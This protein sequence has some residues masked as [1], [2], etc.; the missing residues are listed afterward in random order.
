[1]SCTESTSISRRGMVRGGASLALWGLLPRP[2]IAAGRDPR[3]LCVILRGG[4][5][6]ISMVAP[7][8]DPDYERLRGK[9][10]IPRGGVGAGLPLDSFFV[11]NAGMPYLHSLYR[12]KQALILH[13]IQSPYRGRSHFDGQDVLESGLAGVGR[14]DD[15]WLNR[16]LASLPSVG[17][18]EPMKGLAMGAVVP[19]VIRGSAPIL[20]WIPKANSLPLRDSTIERLQDLYAETD[21]A[22]AKAFADGIEI[23]RV[24]GMGAGAVPPTAAK[25]AGTPAQPPQPRPFREFTDAAEAAAKFLAAPGGPRIGALSFSGWD[26]HSNEGVITGQLANRLAG[27]DACIK[28]FAEAMGAAWRETVVAIVTEFGRTAR[29]NGTDGTDHGTATVA[30]VVG[31]AVAGGR[32]VADWP[33]LKQAQLY[34]DRDLKPTSDLRSALKGVLRDHLGIPAGVLAARVFPDSAKAAPMDGLVA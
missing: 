20:S 2:S 30:L 21:P 15:G 4:L 32:I 22:L 5:D 29:A 19:L 34:E 18:V 10:A 16:A 11:L 23:E 9:L 33:G 24:A 7:V 1:M 3:L 14:A 31:G 13:A 27:L 6:G 8:G 28:A 17:R 25:P 12:S 26:T